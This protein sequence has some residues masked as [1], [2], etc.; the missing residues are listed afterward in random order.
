MSDYN[1]N[2]LGGL[3][4]HRNQK[5]VEACPECWIKLEGDGKPSATTFPCLV[6]GCPYE[7]NPKSADQHK[8]SL[9]GNGTAL[10]AEL[11]NYNE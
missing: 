6:A 3:A 7:T 2:M 5:G 8:P 4:R 9:T 11:G 1:L 10:C